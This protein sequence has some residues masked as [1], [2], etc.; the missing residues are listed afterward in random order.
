VK[1]KELLQRIEALEKRIQV[2]EEHTAR[3]II[4]KYQIGR[5]IQVTVPYTAPAD[6]CAAGIHDYPQM[7]GGINPPCC[8]RCGHSMPNSYRI[9]C[10]GTTK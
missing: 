6:P 10:T 1:K 2:L 5:P 8:R 7:W 4:E 3:V 9:T